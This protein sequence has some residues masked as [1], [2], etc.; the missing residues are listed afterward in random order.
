MKKFLL[1]VVFLLGIIS[2]ATAQQAVSLES[3][4]IAVRSVAASKDSTLTVSTTAAPAAKKKGFKDLFDN[5]QAAI[6]GPRLNPRAISF[7]RT[8]SKKTAK[9]SKACGPG[10]SRILT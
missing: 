10:A 8:I 1:P 3:T 4:A 5:D 9:T 6:A 2:L 7:V